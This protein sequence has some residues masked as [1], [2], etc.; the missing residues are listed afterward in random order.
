MLEVEYRARG[1]CLA[2]VV[3][4][5]EPAHASVATCFSA[6]GRLSYKILRELLRA[7]FTKPMGNGEAYLVHT[8]NV[9]C[10]VWK[11]MDRADG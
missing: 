4:D 8:S 3:G 7:E 6:E 5:L 2:H 1:L 10:H 9:V 11:Q